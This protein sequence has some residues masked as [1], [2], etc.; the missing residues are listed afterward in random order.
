MASSNKDI[1]NQMRINKLLNLLNIRSPRGG[2]SCSEMAEACGVTKRSIYRYLVYI[3][4]VL[5]VSIIRPK[6]NTVYKEGLYRLDAGFLPMISPDKALIIFLILL[7]QKGS[8]LACHTNEI[9]DALVSTLFTFKVPPKSLQVDLLQERIYVVEEQLAEPARVGEIFSK[10]ALSLMKSYRVKLFYF[11]ASRNQDSE[12]VVEPYGLICKRHNW[13][14][15]AH[16][17]TR[18][19]IRVFRVDQIR[20]INPYP[21]EHFEYPAD[22]S[23]KDYMSKSWG[24]MSDGEVCKV[25]L[26]FSPE[27]ARRVK[28]M[29]YHSSQSVEE[30]LDDG[31]VI[32]SFEICGI[33]EMKTW[34]V[35]WGDAVEVLEPGWLREDICD[36]ARRI[37]E[38]YKL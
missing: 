3:E 23:L 15:I 1:T 7:Q 30:Q 33:N 24:V 4:N 26:R 6:K 2:I 11:V 35:Q 10:L 31:S 29:I 17:G 5:N 36:M 20:D 16:C 8:A 13:Y 27:F 32:L 38:V 28:N 21:S 37:L 9:R 19:A 22:F 14:L 34:L 18:K 25:R 12:R